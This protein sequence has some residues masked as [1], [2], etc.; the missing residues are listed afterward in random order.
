MTGSSQQI[1]AN[2]QA[3]AWSLWT[4]LGVRGVERH[5]PD[6]AI[7]PEPLILFTSRLQ[8][9][10]PRLRD[11]SIDWCLHNLRFV[12]VARLRN[13]LKE[14]DPTLRAAF[15]EYA[16]IV[17]ANSSARW[18][19]SD[20]APTRAFHPSGKSAS[21]DL[22]RPALIH[23]RLRSLFGVSARAECIVALLARPNVDLSC[24]DLARL[25]SYTK[26]NVSDVMESLRA[27]GLVKATKTGNQVRYRLD[28]RQELTGLIGHL[29]T[30]FPAWGSLF[31]LLDAILQLSSRLQAAKPE[32]AGVE[33]HQ[34]LDKMKPVLEQ[35]D[36]TAPVRQPTAAAYWHS[37]VDWASQLTSNLA[38]GTSGFTSDL[39]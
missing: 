18:P 1:S 22:G 4:E 3:L 19:R 10:D 20:G 11:E 37:F 21:P 13:L 36:L 24:A 12:S 31:R 14:A 7:D 8:G 16:S 23:L 34:D 17:N 6:W 35:L 29:P 5:H 39:S 26:R 27:A 2:L 9:S 32:V 38:T 33:A 30:I 28:R 15:S 25:T